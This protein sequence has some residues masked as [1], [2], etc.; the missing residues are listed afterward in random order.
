M[1]SHPFIKKVELEQGALQHGWT[2]RV[3]DRLPDTPIHPIS[4]GQPVETAETTKMGK[5]TLQLL[6]FKGDFLKPCP[7]TQS[8]ICCGYQITLA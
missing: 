7:G 1:A 8:Y 3:L 6:S 4:P 5:D 2:H